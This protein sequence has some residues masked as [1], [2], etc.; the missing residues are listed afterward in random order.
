M[1]PRITVAQLA[2]R[3]NEQ[4]AKLDQILA[5]IAG[6]QVT[7]VAD[8]PAANTATI[9]QADP[10]NVTIA[11]TSPDTPATPATPRNGNAVQSGGLVLQPRLRTHA[12]KENSGLDLIIKAVNAAPTGGKVT[13]PRKFHSAVNSRISMS[14]YPSRLAKWDTGNRCHEYLRGTSRERKTMADGSRLSVYVPQHGF[15]HTGSTDITLTILADPQP[16]KVG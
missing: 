1:A 11:D 10:A 8:V 14:S 3:V 7:P 15:G 13:Y 5:A 2:L 12:V 6:A 4:D 16:V 9:E